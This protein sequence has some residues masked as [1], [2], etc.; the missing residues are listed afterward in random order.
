MAY[1]IQIKYSKNDNFKK[2]VQKTRAFKMEFTDRIVCPSYL[3]NLNDFNMMLISL[4]LLGAV[5]FWILYKSVE[6]FDKI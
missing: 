5:M 6:F 3:I 1:S 2:N 4:I